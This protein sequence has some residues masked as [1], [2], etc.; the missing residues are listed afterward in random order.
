MTYDEYHKA[1]R[2]KYW[3]KGHTLEEIDN[4]PLSFLGDIMGFEKETNRI[5]VKR[6]RTARK[7]KGNH[8]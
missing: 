5:E 7:L 4:L 2:A 6:A 8:N 3:L 1:I